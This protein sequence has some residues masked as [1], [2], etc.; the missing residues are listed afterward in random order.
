VH[1]SHETARLYLIEISHSERFRGIECGSIP[2]RSF[3]PETA[4][5]ARGFA[6]HAVY[7]LVAQLGANAN[8]FMPHLYTALA[9][10]ER[11]LIS[12]RTRAALASRKS[13]GAKLGNPTNTAAA[14]AKGRK[15]S[16]DEAVRFAESV[17]PIIKSVQLSGI[18]SLRGLAIA[19]NNRGVRI[20]RGGRWQV[21]NVAT[22]WRGNLLRTCF[23][24]GNFSHR[25]EAVSDLP[26][27]RSTRAH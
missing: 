7:R 5:Y 11:R 21:S 26:R 27:T 19:L 6:I 17:L 8:P 9:E 24:S 3:T 23:I 10:K 12:E 1:I 18:T 25:T 14:A 13:T 2:S 16:I 20:A 15:I 4:R 22:S